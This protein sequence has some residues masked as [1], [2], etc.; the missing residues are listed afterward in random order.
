MNRPVGVA[1]SSRVLSLNG[2]QQWPVNTM[3]SGSYRCRHYATAGTTSETRATVVKKRATAEKASTAGKPKSSG[4]KGA[5]SPRKGKSA[6]AKRKTATKTK[7]KAATKPKRKSAAAKS[8]P[9]KVVKK[10]PAKELTDEEKTAKKIR[11]LKKLALKSPSGP[12]TTAWTMVV[13][14]VMNKNI[15]G[16][17]AR[18]GMKNASEKY[19]TLSPAEQEVRVAARKNEP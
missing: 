8:K 5:A 18:G 16:A 15:G 3:A 7:A 2:S 19:K 6:R 11:E 1:S 17:A 4:S 12:P 13:A 9:K 14:E 10:T